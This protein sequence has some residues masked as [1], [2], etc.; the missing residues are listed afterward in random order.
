MG[1]DGVSAEFDLAVVKQNGRAI[2]FV[3]GEIDRSVKDMI[4]DALRSA[5][6]ESSDVIVD[7]SRVSFMDSTGINALIGARRRA[8]G[9][10]FHVVG[11]TRSVRRV[12]EVMGLAELLLE[13]SSRLTWQQI[14][15]HWCGWRQWMTVECTRDGAPIAEIVEVGPSDGTNST[16]YRLEMG[17][18]MAL[19]GSLDDAMRAAS[20]SRAAASA[21]GEEQRA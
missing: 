7:L 17:G 10:Q 20:D 5:Q 9:R 18:R 3:A 2:V 15:Y 19:Y 11:A 8:P 1:R 13:D 12:F 21:T 14:T 16:R 6:L 4:H